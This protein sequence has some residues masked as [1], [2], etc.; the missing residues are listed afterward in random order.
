MRALWLGLLFVSL[1]SFVAIDESVAAESNN[2]GDRSAGER[3]FEG[4]CSGCHGAKGISMISSI[5]RLGAQ[6]SSFLLFQ[7]SLFKSGVRPDQPGHAKMKGIGDQEIRSIVSYL[8]AQ[9]PGPPW[10]TQNP[11]LRDAGEKLYQS[12]EYGRKIIACAVCHAK[13]GA[14]VDTLTVP[15]VANQSP[16][17]LDEI[18]HLF[19]T[20]MDF[21]TPIGNGM[22]LAVI[23]LTDE[24]IKAVSEYMATLGAGKDSAAGENKGSGK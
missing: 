23:P 14:G 17:Y 19:K 7:W 9:P 15:R 2:N 10:P 20:P 6:V 3:L 13:D 5:P 12:G 21:H 11:K 4:T 16:L 1:F 8:S 22:H 18:L 24:D